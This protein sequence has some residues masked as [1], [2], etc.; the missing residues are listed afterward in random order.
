MSID[1]QLAE[2]IAALNA[3]TAALVAAGGK[4]GNSAASTTTTGGETKT[5]T[6]TTTKGKTD[7]PKITQEQVNAAL[8]KIK[9]E[10]GMP[11]AKAIIKDIGKVEKMGE[12]KPATYQAVYDAAVARYEELANGSGG[13][14]EDGNDL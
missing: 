12:I 11:E 10:F 6:K 14:S 8:I 5:T 9:D 13:G 2:L 7:E 3:N 4:S 1:T